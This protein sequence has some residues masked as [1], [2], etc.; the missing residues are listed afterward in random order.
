MSAETNLQ[1]QQHL[2]EL[3]EQRAFDR[4]GEVWAE[5][6]VDHD[7]APNQAAGVQGIV[8]FWTEF[9]SAFPDVSLTPETL[10]ADDD[11]VTGVFTITGTHGGDFQGHPATGKS[12][13]VRGIQVAKF[14]DGRIVERWGSTDEKGLADQLGIT[15]KAAHS[16]ASESG[17]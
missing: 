15:P 4:F 16:V 6:V 11:Q 10:V 12:F 17:A 9:T 14:R 3:I 8:D 2:G 5:D 7:P 13:T 1:A